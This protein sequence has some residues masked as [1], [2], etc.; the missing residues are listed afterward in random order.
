MKQ[1]KSAIFNS[2]IQ[3]SAYTCS[4][5][6][7][8]CPFVAL[9]NAKFAEHLHTVLSNP[10]QIA[11]ILT[12]CVF[13][14]VFLNA[15]SH[16]CFWCAVLQGEDGS[17]TQHQQRGRRLTSRPRKPPSWASATRGDGSN[18]SGDVPSMFVSDLMEDTVTAPEHR[19]RMIACAPQTEKYINNNNN[20]NKYNYNNNKWICIVSQYLIKAGWA[21]RAL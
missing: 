4:C 8:V 2:N 12:S 20:K 13:W 11:F 7:S 21:H 6:I 14:F 15:G 10:Y 9:L 5:F 1:T 18:H 3:L 16:V 19:A 17:G